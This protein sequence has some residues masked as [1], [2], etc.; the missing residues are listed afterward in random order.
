MK[1]LVVAG[2][3]LFAIGFGMKFFH[4]PFHA[5]V[6]F[7]GILLLVIENVSYA[8]QKDKIAPVLFLR[9]ATNIILIYLLFLVKF[10]PFSIVPVVVGF[11]SISIGIFL[12]AKTKRT[13][14][15]TLSRATLYPLMISIIVSATVYFIPS[16]QRYY[17]FNIKFNH[18]IETDY[19]TWDK[20]SWFLYIN[21]RPIDA[22]RASEKALE[23][24][25]QTTD[26]LSFKQI[27]SHRSKIKDRSWMSFSH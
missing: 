20:Y 6:M 25:S 17:I 11:V 27:Q 7:M 5:L 15:A 1:K 9:L 16:H 19:R 26:E 2:Y 21:N 10:Y 4:A 13:I 3:G 23:I 14:P 24:V 22:E 12:M 18:E 8:L